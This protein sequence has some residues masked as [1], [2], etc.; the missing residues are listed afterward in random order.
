M[1]GLPSQLRIRMVLMATGTPPSRRGA[2]PTPSANSRG[3]DVHNHSP[4]RG[5][6]PVA[7]PSLAC[8]RVEKRSRNR[9]FDPEQ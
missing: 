2:S 7:P 5:R 8:F 3:M 9:E 6:F 4:S 1:C